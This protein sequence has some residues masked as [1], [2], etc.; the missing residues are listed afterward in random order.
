[1]NKFTKFTKFLNV[2]WYGVKIVLH[3]IDEKDKVDKMN[4]I[5]KEFKK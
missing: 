1:M 4:N 2:L 3:L 5:E